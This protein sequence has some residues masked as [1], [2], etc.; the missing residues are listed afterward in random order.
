MSILN[1]LRQS[2]TRRVTV[3]SP[4][5]LSELKS[6][7]LESVGLAGFDIHA[8]LDDRNLGCAKRY[9]M[10]RPDSRGVSMDGTR[11]KKV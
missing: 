4:N 5:L 3:R 2:I 7:R 8:S 9:T 10:R 11:L 6:S 1:G